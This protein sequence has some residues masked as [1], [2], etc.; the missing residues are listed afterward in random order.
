VA[1]DA[2]KQ[3]E[4]HPLNLSAWCD[5]DRTYFET[6]SWISQSKVREVSKQRSFVAPPAGH[7]TKK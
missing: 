2:Q 5:R 3:K 4:C 6:E 7:S 1:T